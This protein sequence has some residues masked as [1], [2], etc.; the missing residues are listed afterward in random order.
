MILNGNPMRI[1][2]VKTIKCMNGAQKKEIMA[3]AGIW[4]GSTI[5]TIML[6]KFQEQLWFVLNAAVENMVCIIE[7]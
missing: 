2:A 5:L 3:M 7:D 4:K 6:I 1:M